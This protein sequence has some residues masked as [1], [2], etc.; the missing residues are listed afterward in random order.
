MY[1]FILL[2]VALVWGST[3]FIIKDTVSSVNEYFIVFGRTFI[4]AVV[5]IIVLFVKNRK[6]FFHREAIIKG[7]ILG[8]LLALTYISQTI[9]LK[10]T[11]AGHSAFI[12]GAAVVVVPLILFLFFKHRLNKIDVFSV[13]VV[14][15]GLFLLTYN[16][17]L[18]INIGD[19]IT[20]ITMVSFALNLVL[21]G[22]YVKNSEVLAIVTYQFI[23]AS[24]I[25]G[26]AYLLSDTAPLILSE[27]SVWAILYLGFLGTLFCY[28]ITVWIQKYVNTLKL[29]VVFSFEPIFAAILA[30]I[31]ISEVLSLKEIIGAFIIILG[32][33]TF[34]VWE[35]LKNRKMSV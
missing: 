5:M 30:Y 14:F 9:G 18:K 1:T 4:A 26:I 17:D 29:A 11:S 27:K 35:Y 28:F 2:L 7:G 15:I 20:L 33:I 12:T 8:I 10:Y 34:Q 21:A 23:T 22:R 32:V 13:G 16:S 31:M 19:I 24:I 25:S 6:A 3:F